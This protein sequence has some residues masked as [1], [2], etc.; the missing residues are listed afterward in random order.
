MRRNFLVFGSP[1]KI[2]R[3]ENDEV[4]ACMESGLARHG[5]ESRPGVREDFKA[6]KEARHAVSREFLHRGLLL[7]LLWPRA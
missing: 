6:Y 3:S 2:E 4:V 7:S 1:R 5:A